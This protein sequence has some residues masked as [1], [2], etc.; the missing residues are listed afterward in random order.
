MEN[1]PRF[2]PFPLVIIFVPKIIMLRMAIDDPNPGYLNHSP[3]SLF[4][5]EN[6]H[7]MAID[8]AIKGVN[9]E[10]THQTCALLINH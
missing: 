2:E 3:W 8:D 7:F 5:F 4:S 10:N 6:Y 9:M 1:G